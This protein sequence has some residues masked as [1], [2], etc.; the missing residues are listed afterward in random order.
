MIDLNSD[1]RTTNADDASSPAAGCRQD[2][3]LDCDTGPLYGHTLKVGG[4]LVADYW[5]FF[6]YNDTIAPRGVPGLGQLGFDHEGDWEGV[7]LG[8]PSSTPTAA[9]PDWVAMAGHKDDQPRKYLLATL[10]CDGNQ[11]DASCGRTYTSQT[12]STRRTG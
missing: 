2:G 5:W 6:R 12:D 1:G 7:S 8:V 9:R 10:S 11:D 4:Y 3:R